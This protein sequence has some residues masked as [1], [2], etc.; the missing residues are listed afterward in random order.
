LARE[1]DVDLGC[2][3]PARIRREIGR[4]PATEAARPASPAASP[5]PDPLVAP[6]EAVL[7]TWHQLIDLG[8]LAQNDEYLAGT[9]RPSVVRVGKAIAGRLG[10]ADGDRVTV[11]TPRGAITLPAAVTDMADGVVWVPTNSTGSTVRRTLGVTSGAVVSVSAAG[12]ATSE[13]AASAAGSDGAATT[14]GGDL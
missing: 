13:P 6:N 2:D 14:R 12:P 9:A 8:R 3:D 5:V 7:A 10:V 11:S 1:F 4:T